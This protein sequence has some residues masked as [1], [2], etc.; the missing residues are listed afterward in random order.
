MTHVKN[1]VHIII[2]SLVFML[3]SSIDGRPVTQVDVDGTLLDVEASFCYLGNM[4]SADG[5]CSF[6]II[7]WC[8]TAWGKFKKLLPILTSKQISLTVRGKVFDACVRSALL[9]GSET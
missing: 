5:I 3:Q 8:C 4:L 9:N 7:T 1:N 6:A 2:C